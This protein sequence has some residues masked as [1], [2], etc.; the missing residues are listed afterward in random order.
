MAE[1]TDSYRDGVFVKREGINPTMA[2]R[3]GQNTSAVVGYEYFHDE[4]VADRGITSQGNRPYNTDDSTFFGNQDLSPTESR[5]HAF[6]AV[7]DH[8]FGNGFT[9]RNR[10][11]V[12]DYDKFYQ[13]IY[14]SGAARTDGY[15][16]LGAYNQDTQ[17][18]NIFNQTDLFFNFNTGSVKHKIVT[19]L[20]LGR[21]ETQN[22]R[23]NGVFPVVAGPIPAN[24]VRLADP[25]YRGGITFRAATSND[26]T[27]DALSVYLQDQ[28]EITPQWQV[29]AG[30]RADRFTVDFTNRIDNSRIEVKDTPLSP[31]LGLVYKPFE[32]LS[33]YG[34]YSETFVPRSGEQ[35]AS[36][37]ASVASFEPEQFTN[38]EVGAKWDVRPDLSV[39]AAI[40]QLD[41]SNVLLTAFPTATESTLIEGDAQTSK[42]VEIGVAG[43]ITPAW[44]VF[45]GYAYQKAQLTK[46]GN[47][48]VLNGADLPHVPKHMLSLWNRYDLDANWG[49]GLGLSYRGA[50]NAGITGPVV[51]PGYTR[52]DT[53]LFYKFNNQYQLQANIENLLN[54]RYYASAHSNTN[55]TPGS[56]RALRVTLNAKF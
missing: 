18:K 53:A 46:V 47:S 39:T 26:G 11:R 19:G 2:F 23:Q 24:R 7:L 34:S 31:R 36:L 22:L 27:A 41:R 6:T 40:Y 30:L 35:L 4:R 56:P 10:T 28:I 37:T 38:M 12:A 50:V 9:L 3:L 21:Q 48:G 33:L 52:V 54:K 55:I 29:I 49:A 1:R 42:G 44:S 17:R 25:I 5:V 15:V 45:G 51:L 14:A 16:D 13:N 32:A 43:K 8:D 20:E